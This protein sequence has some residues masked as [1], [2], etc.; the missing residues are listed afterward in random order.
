VNAMFKL[1]MPWKIPLLCEALS[2]DI[3]GITLTSMLGFMLAQV[4]SMRIALR[5]LVACVAFRVFCDAVQLSL[6]DGPLMTV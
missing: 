5:T 4:L 1:F 6:L 3:A 2:T